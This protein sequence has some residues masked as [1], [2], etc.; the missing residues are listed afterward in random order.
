MPKLGLCA[1][2]RLNLRDRVLS[3]IEN[4]SFIALLGKGGHSGLMLKTVCPNMGVRF[5]EE[6]YSDGS[7]SRLLIRMGV[8]AGPAISVHLA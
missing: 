5:G 1:C 3:E 7:R 4:D 2:A 6:F 8:C